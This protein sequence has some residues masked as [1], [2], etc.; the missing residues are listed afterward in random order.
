MPFS[1]QLNFFQTENTG[2]KNS[3]RKNIPDLKEA[4][5]SLSDS[6]ILFGSYVDFPIHN[7]SCQT[8]WSNNCQTITDNY[9]SPKMSN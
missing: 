4:L 8:L 7:Q 1:T 3:D 2:K 5:F 6:Q 9:C